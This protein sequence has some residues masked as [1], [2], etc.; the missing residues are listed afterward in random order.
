MDV[1]KYKYDNFPGWNAFM[2][3]LTTSCSDFQIFTIN[4]LPFVND[5]SNNYNT[6][7]TTLLNVIDKS[8]SLGIK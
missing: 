3:M 7:Y 2:N 6:L 4:Y 5:A 8:L 1:L